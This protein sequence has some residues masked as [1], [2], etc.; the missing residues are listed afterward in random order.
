MFPGFYL[1]ADL[2]EYMLEAL[3][4]WVKDIGIDGYR[5]DHPHVTPS[6]FWMRARAKME[7]IKPVIM[8][9][10]N[11]DRVEF[12][13]NGFDMNYSWELHHMMNQVAQ[14]KRKYTAMDTLLMKDFETFPRNAYRLRFI[15]NHDENSW[16]GTIDERMGDAHKAFAVFMYTIPGVPLIYNGQEAGLNKRLKFFERDPI[17]WREPELREFYK[18]LNTL[19]HNNPA[20]YNGIYGGSFNQ[21]MAF[22]AENVFAYYRFIGDN[23]LVTC[24]N[25]SDKPESFHISATLHGD[26]R[27]VFTGDTV[28]ISGSTDFE[29]GPWEYVVLSTR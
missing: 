20:I 24:I 8:L 25:F 4:Y 13:E 22:G 6:D 7:E 11:E 21:M 19:K 26:F 27:N 3:I 1:N 10:E 2:Q 9:A 23:K 15:T 16:A 12:F 28:I 17:E 5:V 14:G 29:L 18:T